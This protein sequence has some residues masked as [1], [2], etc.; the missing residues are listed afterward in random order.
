MRWIYTFKVSRLVNTPVALDWKTHETLDLD[1]CV[2]IGGTR[3]SHLSWMVTHLSEWE[4]THAYVT[5]HPHVWRLGFMNHVRISEKAYDGPN[6]HWEW[7]SRYLLHDMVR[8][9]EGSTAWALGHYVNPYM[10]ST[11]LRGWCD[12]TNVCMMVYIHGW[13]QSEQV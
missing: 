4:L 12:V 5:L 8:V 6:L 11:I 10:I 9:V 3:K 7:L 13:V 1:R 2:I